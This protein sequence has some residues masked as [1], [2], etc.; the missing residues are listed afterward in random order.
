[1]TLTNGYSNECSIF[2]PKFKV[3]HKG[4]FLTKAQ[5]KANKIAEKM[6]KKLRSQL[7]KNS[8][9]LVKDESSATYSITKNE[10]QCVKKGR[11][12]NSYNAM[13]RHCIKATAEIDIKRNDTG[14]VLKTLGYD[15]VSKILNMKAKPYD[16]FKDA[17]SEIP[18]CWP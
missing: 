2:V 15:E 9:I 13:V 1:M 5:K 3:P 12:D 10:T 14:D 8:F 18:D 7:N 4:I 6:A 17:L 11:V 16:A